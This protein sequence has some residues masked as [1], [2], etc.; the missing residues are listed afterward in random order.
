ML[1]SLW[2]RCADE[3]DSKR[4]RVEQYALWAGAFSF[5]RLRRHGESR[6]ASA[7]IPAPLG[8][9]PAPHA[10]QAITSCCTKRKPRRAGATAPFAGW[11]RNNHMD[12]PM[13]TLKHIVKSFSGREAAVHAVR[14]V[15]L[16]I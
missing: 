11:E 15:S 12:T 3:T 13:I 9:D 2:P 8:F 16:T 6:F 4:L 7:R 14:D 1:F 10:N 5:L